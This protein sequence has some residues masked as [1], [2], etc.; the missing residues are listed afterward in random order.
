MFPVWC[1]FGVWGDC[2]LTK[3]HVLVKV[4]LAAVEGVIKSVKNVFRG[5]PLQPPTVVP[6]AIPS[7]GQDENISWTS[8]LN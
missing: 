6:K 1:F 7:A 3:V 2:L 8:A 4:E 5:P